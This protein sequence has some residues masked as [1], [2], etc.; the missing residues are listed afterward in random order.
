MSDQKRKWGEEGKVWTG[1]N[2]RTEKGRG[3]LGSVPE[4]VTLGAPE[5]SAEG[6]PPPLTAPPMS[7]RTSYP[8]RIS[9][10]NREVDK[11]LKVHRRT[12]DWPLS[13]AEG[14]QLRLS[15]IPRNRGFLE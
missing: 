2:V 4:P 3:P 11:N 8:R 13:N 7:R 9:P 5:Y 6:P 15:Y 10:N 14:R 1:R 12:G